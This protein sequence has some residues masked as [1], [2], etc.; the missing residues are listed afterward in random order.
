EMVEV[1]FT[2]SPR[3][4]RIAAHSPHQLPAEEYYRQIF[5]SSGMDLPDEGFKRWMEEV[6]LDLVELPAHEKAIL[7]LTLPAEFI[8]VFEP[9]T[10]TAQFIDVKGEPTRER[11]SLSMVFNNLHA[12]TGTVEKRPGPLRIALE[13]KTDARVLPTIWIAG[14]K[15]HDLLGH[16]RTFLTAK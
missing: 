11:Q 10:H 7:S 6:T 2:V 8:I 1:T 4:R 9:V 16:R 13:N 3:V 15:L 14:D 5:W 12:P